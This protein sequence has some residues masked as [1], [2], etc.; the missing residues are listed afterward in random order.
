MSRAEFMMETGVGNSD[1]PD[2]E[3]MVSCSIDGG[4]SFSNE[5]WIKI[6]REGESVR[7]VEWYNMKG[8]YDL[9]LR[10]RVSDPNFI[11]IHSA[12]ID[13]KEAGW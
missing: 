5:D 11:S 6:G 2:P 10:V 9:I 13:V 8:F 7:R 1:Q 12:S 4:R 3:I